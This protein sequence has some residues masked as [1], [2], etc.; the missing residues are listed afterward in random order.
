MHDQP[1]GVE[2]LVYPCMQDEHITCPNQQGKVSL[3]VQINSS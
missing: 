2:L 1:R 3:E